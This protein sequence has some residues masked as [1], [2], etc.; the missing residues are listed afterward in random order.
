LQKFLAHLAAEKGIGFLSNQKTK[1]PNKMN[2]ETFEFSDKF[3]RGDM[4]KW[5]ASDFYED[6]REE[7]VV[8]ITSGL[9]FDTDWGGCKKEILSSRI[10]CTGDTFHCEVSVSDDFD[11]PGITEV[12]AI[13]GATH[14]ETML[15]IEVALNTATDL[16]R[17]DQKNNREYRGFTIRNEKGSW[18]ETYIQDTGG[19]GN[20]Y[21][22]GDNYAEWG[23]QGD[24]DSIPEDVKKKMEEWI[25]S[26]P[27]NNTSLQVE[28]W[29]ISP[30]DD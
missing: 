2:T 16:A 25:Q 29:L 20:E 26:Y 4:T 11:T 10:T 9:P 14:E 24:S 15:N 8:A 30:W 23:F 12:L 1:K 19:W 5:G 27:E 13:R 18:A 22:P 7:I 28:G 3:K 17:E 21:P 6:K